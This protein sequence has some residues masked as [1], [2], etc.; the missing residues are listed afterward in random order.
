MTLPLTKE[1]LASAYDFLCSTPPF[2]KWGMP[3]SEDVQFII[4]R[5]RTVSGIH[6][7]HKGKHYIGV[8]RFKVGHTSTLVVLMAHEMLHLHISHTGMAKG[9]ADHGRTF[10]KLAKQ[11]CKVHGFDPHEF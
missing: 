6:S 2:N 4:T 11:V 1:I 7:F 8:S 9:E 5:N 3:E 10:F